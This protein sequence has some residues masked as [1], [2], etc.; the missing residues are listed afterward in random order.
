MT[1]GS[2]QQKKWKN[3]ISKSRNQLPRRQQSQHP[4]YMDDMNFD[5]KGDNFARYLNYT[6]VQ[7]YH[8][9]PE[10]FIQKRRKTSWNEVTRRT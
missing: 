1:H 9:T 8:T 2:G 6:S 4:G 10:G 7:E 5:D 3:N